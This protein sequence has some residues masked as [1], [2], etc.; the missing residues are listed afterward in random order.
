MLIS[1]Q[2][3]NYNRIYTERK[4]LL[5]SIFLFPCFLP[6]SVDNLFSLLFSFF[7]DLFTSFYREQEGGE[8]IS[9][10]RLPA[11]QGVQLRAYPTTHEIMTWAKIK[12]QGNPG[13]L[14]GLVPAFDSGH[15]PRIPGSSPTS[16]SLPGDCFSLCLCL[17]HRPPRRL[18]LMNK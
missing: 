15:D 3:Q 14:S 2:S 13:W 5:P 16:G 6:S 9:Q 12:S 1:F 4:L 10:A 8:R 7:K 17:C 18:S 11:E